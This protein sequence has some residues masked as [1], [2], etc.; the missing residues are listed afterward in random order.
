MDILELL[1]Y[2]IFKKKNFRNRSKDG[3]GYG[4]CGLRGICV[5]FPESGR[6]KNGPTADPAGLGLFHYFTL[7]K[8]EKQTPVSLTLVH[9]ISS[10]VLILMVILILGL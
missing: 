9:R 2:C 4:G 3:A 5:R 7:N 1:S 6:D 10:P 8:S